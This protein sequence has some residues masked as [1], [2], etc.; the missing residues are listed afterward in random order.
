MFSF[1]GFSR[2]ENEP[3]TPVL[4]QQE[5]DFTPR[6]IANMRKNDFVIHS[7][8]QMQ[9]GR[10]VAATKNGVYFWN[11]SKMESAESI[12][13]G[14]CGTSLASSYSSICVMH[15]GRLVLGAYG[16]QYYADY[17]YCNYMKVFLDV[18]RSKKTKNVYSMDLPKYRKNTETVYHIPEHSRGLANFQELQNG[19]LVGTTNGEI[20]ILSSSLNKIRVRIDTEQ[21]KINAL[22]QLQNG[23]LV[24]GSSTGTICIWDPDTGQKLNTLDSGR[25]DE[26]GVLAL[27]QY[28]DGRLIAL[29]DECIEFW[30]VQTGIREVSI[31]IMFVH[32][33]GHESF[34]ESV[35]LVEQEPEY[36]QGS[37]PHAKDEI[38]RTLQSFCK[39]PNPARYKTRSIRQSFCN[40][41]NPDEEIYSNSSKTYSLKLLTDGRL[42]VIG[43]IDEKIENTLTFSRKVIAKIYDVTESCWVQDI[44][45]EENISTKVV[46][47]QVEILLDGLL[48]VSINDRIKIWDIGYRP[49]L[50]KSESRLVV[51]NPTTN[52]AISTK[53]ADLPP[54]ELSSSGLSLTKTTVTMAGIPH[55]SSSAIEINYNRQLGEGGFGVVYEASWLRKTV[56]VK[57][58]RAGHLSEEALSSFQEEAQRHG[59]LRHPNILTLYGVCIEPGK[60]YIVTELMTKGSLDR[61]L[62]SCEQLPWSL[63]LSI[64][65]N[66]T[67]GL[68]YLHENMIIHCDLKSLNVLL[69]ANNKACLADFGLAKVRSEA[70]GLTSMPVKMSGTTRWKAPELFIRGSRPNILSDI[71]ALG[72]VLWE[73]VSRKF[74]FQDDA[75][76]D[77]SIITWIKD[78]EREPIPE[79]IPVKYAELIGQCWAQNAKARPQNAKIIAERLSELE[80][81]YNYFSKK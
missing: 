70:S 76:D 69:D 22:I 31:P 56:A 64:A 28:T 68:Y 23:R 71:Y 21:E 4:M 11:L 15:D 78:G 60:Y 44:I 36:W 65:L 33:K 35:Q 45:I 77:A 39:M 30:N 18:Y 17:N 37:V 79:K 46:E 7:L 75:A 48:A 34:E 5:Q 10:L 9:D 42:M 16:D 38:E 8:K 59:L 72:W 43:L 52:S 74:P 29:F 26:Q 40:M 47:I 50:A 55:I 63:Q 66:I 2:R 53:S 57:Q 51:S 3:K 14:S 1:F 19:R 32:D 61:L 58:L 6:L 12:E 49:V 73:I 24:I 62:H 80:Q 27:L 41:S 67:E 25:Q 13:G 20:L 54:P 81:P